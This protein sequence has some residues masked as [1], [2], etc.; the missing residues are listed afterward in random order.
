MKKRFMN[1]GL[2]DNILKVV[3]A[4]LYLI[5]LFNPTIYS[6]VEAKEA[7]SI[8]PGQAIDIVKDCMNAS[9]DELTRLERERIEREKNKPVVQSINYQF[10]VFQPS[11]YTE[12]DLTRMLGNRNG[13]KPL[14]GAFVRAE[15]QYGVNSLYLMSTIGLESGWGRF[16]SGRNNIAGWGGGSGWYNFNSREECIMTVAK[17]LSTHY[18]PNVGTSLYNVSHMYC[19][20]STYQ[21][22]L[23]QIMRE[24]QSNY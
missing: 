5:V 14:V 15:K 9:K 21:N 6:K 11:K 13:L 10:N 18:R 16:E 3:V 22:Q 1:Y 19:P 17:G 12:Q 20:E 4:L 23:M 2:L 8:L 7:P 24:L